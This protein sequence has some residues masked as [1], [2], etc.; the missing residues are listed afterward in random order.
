MKKIAFFLLIAISFIACEKHEHITFDVNGGQTIASFTNAATSDLL[1]SPTADFVT[2]VTVGVSTVSGSA[3]TA[4]ISIDPD[5]TLDPTIYT[6]ESTTV[7]IPAGSFTGTVNITTFAG[8]A[9]NPANQ[10][11]LNLDSV[12]GGRVDPNSIAPIQLI[13]NPAVGCTFIPADTIG[14]WTITQDDFG[15]SVGDNNFD[16]IDGPG[17]NQITMVNPFD[18][19]NPDTGGGYDIIIDVNPVSGSATIE[20]QA[21]WHCNGFGCG[22]GE[23]RVNSIGTGKVLTCAGTMEFDLQH[24]VDAGS[25]GTFAFKASR[26]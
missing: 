15:T 9:F 26:N 22:F 23:G 16:V 6:L 24:T 10:L 20:R 13:F 21:A 11:I 17:E 5:S 3:R 18:H 14:S 4:T 1:V 2:E 7:T 19:T 25:F 12:E 8:S